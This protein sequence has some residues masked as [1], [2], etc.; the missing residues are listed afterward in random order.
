MLDRDVCDA[1][2]GQYPSPPIYG[3]FAPT[4]KKVSI[5]SRLQPIR[6]HFQSADRMC[7]V[8]A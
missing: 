6:I 5:Y 2:H 4:G 7:A 3:H 1:V 8:P